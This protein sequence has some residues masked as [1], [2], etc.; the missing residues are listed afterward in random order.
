[1]DVD[2][3]SSAGSETLNPKLRAEAAPLK[4]GGGA[5][6]VLVPLIR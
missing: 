1:M 6:T 5:C 4:R 2:P 3:E